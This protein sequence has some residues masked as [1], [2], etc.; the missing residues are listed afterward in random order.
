MNLRKLLKD[1]ADDIADNFD[2]CRDVL[3]YIL[4]Q[5]KTRKK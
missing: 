4:E 3:D 1:I 2:N 5:I